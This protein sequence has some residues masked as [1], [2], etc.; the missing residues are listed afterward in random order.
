MTYGQKS[1]GTGMGVRYPPPGVFS[2]YS[3]YNIFPMLVEPE[4]TGSCIGRGGGGGHM[5]TT[6]IP[7]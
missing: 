7:D 4:P 3:V 5:M 1:Q 6:D 2:T